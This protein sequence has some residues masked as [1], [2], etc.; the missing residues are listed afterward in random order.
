MEIKHDLTD[1]RSKMKNQIREN[2][3]NEIKEHLIQTFKLMCE[4]NYRTLNLDFG[5]GYKMV[6]TILETGEKQNEN[7]KH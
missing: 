2:K 5:N 4:E 6:C 1:I 7:N 3:E